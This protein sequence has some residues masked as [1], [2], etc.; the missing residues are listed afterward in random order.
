MVE[1][2]DVCFTCTPASQAEPPR[3]FVVAARTVLLVEPSDPAVLI[4][5]YG[6]GMLGAL[7]ARLR[8]AAKLWGVERS[9][10]LVRRA[11]PYLPPGAELICDDALAFLR[12]TRMRFDVILDDCFVLR[13]NDAVRPAEL[14]RHAELVR[15]R[16]REG[17]LY[18]RNVL[19]EGSLG[20]DPQTADIRAC[21][22]CTRL[23]RFREWDNVLALASGRT[24]APRL[25]RRLEPR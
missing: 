12:R 7:V 2:G 22:R 15:C 24:L 8:P 5:G 18:V 25:L 3:P 19:P 6:L 10:R 17:G 16:L 9:P 4:L 20:S 11:R 13:G 14:R 21:F 1:R 23:R